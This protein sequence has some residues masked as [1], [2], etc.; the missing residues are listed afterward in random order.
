[1]HGDRESV[2]AGGLMSYGANT[3]DGVRAAATFVDKIFKGAKPADLPVEQPTKFEFVINSRVAKALGLTIP[4]SLLLRADQVIKRTSSRVVDRRA[5]ARAIS[6][7]LLAAPFAAEGQQTGEVP[8]VGFLAPIRSR[9]ANV[10]RQ[11]LRRL[12]YAEGQQ[13]AIEYRSANGRFERLPD[14]AAELVSL[15]VEVI[16]AVVTQAALAAKRQTAMIPI[17]MVGVSDPVG[18]GLVMNL[19]RPGG[20]VTGTSSEAADVVGKQLELR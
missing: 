12:G 6:L 2:E 4:P 10:F 18:S 3:R 17:V 13:I 9:R 19:A 1:M 20:N 11:E 16:V 5:F 15:K 8:R 7:G 14:L